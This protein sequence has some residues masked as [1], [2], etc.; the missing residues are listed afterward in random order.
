VL[1]G[2]A[3]DFRDELV[4]D[5]PG[6]RADID[7]MMAGLGTLKLDALLVQRLL[8]GSNPVVDG[9]LAGKT[10]FSRLLSF[11]FTFF[12]GLALRMTSDADAMLR[13]WV[14]NPKLR[15]VV[16]A[17]WI[18]LGLPP[19]R[20]SGVMMNV[21]VAMQ[22]MEH[23]YYPVG[24]SQK[25]AD[26]L[27][28]AFRERGGEL[29]LAS[30][31]SR[32][33]V[34]GGRARGVELAD[35]RS[36][37]APLVISNAAPQ[38]TYGKLIDREHVPARF[39]KKLGK[40]KCSLGPF[41]VCL[42]LDYDVA[43]HGMAEHEYLLYN[44]YDH[45]ETA[46]ALER[47]E[48]AVLSAYS[49]SRLSPGLAPAGHSTLI[50]TTLL[51]WRPERDWRGRKDE[52]AAEMIA[53]I[54]KKKLP[55]LSK[56]IVVKEILTPED[57]EKLTNSAEG[58]MYGWANTPEQVLSFRLSMKS[59]IYGLY[60]AGHWTRPGTGVTTAIMSGWMLDDRLNSWVGKLVDK[61][62]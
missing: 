8:Y 60:H 15:S 28:D 45:E 62:L 13:R 34:Q 16:H 32:I 52:V 2:G 51:P 56:H 30:P 5:F 50:L 42:G 27:A 23:T 4:K 19:G 61:V 17:S 33:V 37:S 24:G 21:F 54:E 29:L 10:G 22:H 7:R 39:L 6:D 41:R 11:P 9:L 53:M 55:G 31:V 14:K 36:F 58:A 44:T 12:W 38:H 1:R 57:L 25:L 49:P 43:G 20:I 3:E 35:G 40:L 46:R 47:G 48:P 26:A 59:P 18:Y